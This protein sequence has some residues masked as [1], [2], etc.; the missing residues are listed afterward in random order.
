M[1]RLKQKYSSD[2]L[3]YTWIA[4]W[5]ERTE[6]RVFQRVVLEEAPLCN[7]VGFMPGPNLPMGMHTQH[8]SFNLPFIAQEGFFL[9]CPLLC[10][11]FI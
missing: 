5:M 9:N 3:P 8:Q 4:L 11:H 2:S 10:L 1:Y 7:P 6:T